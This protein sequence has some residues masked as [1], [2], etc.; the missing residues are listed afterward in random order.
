M[1]RQRELR[2]Y[3]HDM[4]D[5]A[6]KA[7]RFTTGVD[8][9]A[10]QRNDEKVYA[11]VRAL[12]VIGEAAAQ[13]PPEFRQRYPEVPWQGIMGMRQHLIHGYLGVHLE[14]VW[15]TVQESLP[16]LGGAIRTVLADLEADRQ[17]GEGTAPGGGSP[18]A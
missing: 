14:V 16:A 8:V 11:V 18:S 1:R 10:F 15:Q 7:R 13:R 4:L 6:G 12:E 3:L 5:A 9:A 2:D 17:G